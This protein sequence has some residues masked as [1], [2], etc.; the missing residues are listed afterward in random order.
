M[1]G[2]KAEV[3]GTTGYDE[4]LLSETRPVSAENH[5]IRVFGYEIRVPLRIRHILDHGNLQWKLWTDSLFGG[6]TH[7]VCVV[8]FSC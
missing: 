3:Q 1:T 5:R 8:R 7:N 2:L 6:C 4:E